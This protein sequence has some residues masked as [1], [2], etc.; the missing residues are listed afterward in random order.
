MSLCFGVVYGSTVC[1]VIVCLWQIMN[2]NIV[3]LSMKIEVCD[4]SCC[5]VGT[6]YAAKAIGELFVWYVFEAC[7]PEMYGAVLWYWDVLIAGMVCFLWMDASGHLKMVG[8]I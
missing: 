2:M 5:N 7:V 6:T 4:K 3:V 8:N 1:E